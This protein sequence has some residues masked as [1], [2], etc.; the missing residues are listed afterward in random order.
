MSTTMTRGKTAGKVAPQVGDE[1]VLRATGKDW[2]EWVR[3]LRD[4]GAAK[5]SHKEIAAMLHEEH[6]VA[7]WWSQTVT[8]GYERL[9]GRREKHQVVGGFQVSVT[10]T[11]AAPMAA[12]ERAWRDARARAKWLPEKI[13]IRRSSTPGVM[14]FAWEDGSDVEVRLTSKGEAKTQVAVQV[15]KLRDAKAVARTQQF[16][17]DRLGVLAKGQSDR[18]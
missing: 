8:V 18:A 14:R 13:T 10:R 11:I 1:A 3:V 17:K 5:M 16:W 7:P 15:R 2:K 6:G 9:T 12:C 4:A